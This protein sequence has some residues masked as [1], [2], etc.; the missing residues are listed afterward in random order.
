MTPICMSLPL[1][2]CHAI[3]VPAL[4]SVFK[5]GKHD[6]VGKGFPIIQRVRN[7]EWDPVFDVPA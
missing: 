6:G 3:P 5:L 4:V 1:D 7:V 2:E